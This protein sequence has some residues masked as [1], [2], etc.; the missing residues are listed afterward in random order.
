MS[1]SGAQEQPR[2]TRVLLKAEHVDTPLWDR[3]PGRMNDSI[4]YEELGLSEELA[5][6]LEAWNDRFAAA[7][8]DP[9][10]PEWRAAF[11]ADGAAL[12]EELRAEV[13]AGIEI[14][15]VDGFTGVPATPAPVTS[16]APGEWRWSAE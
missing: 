13:G 4:D 6:K 15:Y 8:F 9:E 7:A 10:D 2:Y 12:A 5:E 3:T 1:D 14:V 16:D 11:T